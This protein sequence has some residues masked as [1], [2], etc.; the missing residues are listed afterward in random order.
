MLKAALTFVWLLYGC[1]VVRG[2]QML[3]LIALIISVS[4]LRDLYVARAGDRCNVFFLI[5]PYSDSSS[6]AH[7]PRRASVMFVGV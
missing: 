4:I 7:E 3:Y 5:V 1:S 2:W 6:T